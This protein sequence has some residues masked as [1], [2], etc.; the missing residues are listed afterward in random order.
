MLGSIGRFC[1][2]LSCLCMPQ[3]GAEHHQ[4]ENF[5]Q[6]CSHCTERESE[7]LQGVFSQKQQSWSDWI[8]GD[9]ARSKICLAVLK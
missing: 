6:L 7:K 8:I 1:E 4:T 9:D 5:V 2:A 3:D